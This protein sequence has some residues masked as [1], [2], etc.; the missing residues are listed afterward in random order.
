MRRRSN[1]KENSLEER[2]LN[3]VRFHRRV[4]QLLKAPARRRD[5]TTVQTVETEAP[6]VLPQTTSDSLSDA[7]SEPAI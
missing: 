2:L 1:S 5:Q 6:E 4:R 7:S 3:I